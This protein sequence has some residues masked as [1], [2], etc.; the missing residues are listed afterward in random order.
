MEIEPG[1]ILTAVEIFDLVRE[2]LQRVEKAIDI[3]SVGSVETVTM[4]GR[5]LQRSGGKRLRPALLLLCS[6]FA[7][8][9]GKTAVQ[10]GA[11]VEMLHAATLVHDDVIDIAQNA[12]R[13]SFRQRPV[14]QSHLRSR[15]GLALH[16]GF[17]S[18]A[19]R[20]QFPCPRPSDRPHPDDGR[21]RTDSTRPHSVASA[22]PKPTA[23]N[24]STARPH[25]S[26]P[27]APGLAPSPRERTPTLRT[28]SASSPGISAW[29]SS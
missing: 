15:R 2:D 26:S 7:G 6:R 5:Y 29:R 3:E 21:R 13:P 24:W 22:S 20:A 4:I 19:A 10:L 18:R 28:S 9:G 23:W 14:G 16:A 11:V 17:S 8:G 12:P 1:Q 27:P 25:V